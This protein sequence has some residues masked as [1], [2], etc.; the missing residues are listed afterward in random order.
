MSEPTRR[1]PDCDADD[2]DRRRFLQTVAASAATLGALTQSRSPLFAA[3][4]PTSAAET[5][6]KGLFDSLTEDQKKKVCFAWDHKDPKRGLLRSFVSNNWNITPQMIRSDFYTQK[7]Q[8]LIH[9]TYKALL[10]PEWLERFGKQTYDDSDKQP[11][12]AKQSI[13]I[14]GEPGSE[15]FELVLTGRHMTLRADGNTGEHVAFGGPIFY[16]HAAHGFSETKNHPDNVFW[17]QAVAANKVY[18]MLD[19]KQRKAALVKKR[20]AEDAVGFQGSKGGFTGLPVTDMTGDQKA[21]LQKVLGMLIEP[22]RVEDRD[23]ALE[24]L[25]VQGGLDR[26]VLTFYEEGDIGEDGVWDNWR[27]E[28]PAFVWYFRGQPHVHVWVNV[29]DDPSVPLNAKG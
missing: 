1:C 18:Q 22:F 16:G 12:G 29:A 28:G 8:L 6:V 11:W 20:P 24:S 15:K 19:G 13:A 9:D 5:V 21:E 23:E 7:Q 2:L 27:L 14:F 4:K 3:P 26:C 10:N 17:P 25:K